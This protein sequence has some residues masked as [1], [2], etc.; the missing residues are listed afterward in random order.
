MRFPDAQRYGQM[1]SQELVA[2]VY[3]TES[4]SSSHDFSKTIVENVKENGEKTQG[5]R[6]N[7]F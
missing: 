6:E 2:T 7:P 3:K 1:T 4:F 5:F